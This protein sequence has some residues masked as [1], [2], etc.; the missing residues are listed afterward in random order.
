MEKATY[1]SANG[2]A[3][4]IKLP[5]STTA[6]RWKKGIDLPPASLSLVSDNGFKVT[7]LW[8]VTPDI[9][10]EGA[11]VSGL[12]QVHDDPSRLVVRVR[13]L[14]KEGQRSAEVAGR[15]CI[16]PDSKRPLFYDLTPAPEELHED[17]L[18]TLAAELDLVEQAMLRSR[19]NAVRTREEIIGRSLKGEAYK[20]MPFTDARNLEL[21]LYKTVKVAAKSDL[22]NRFPDYRFLTPLTM[23]SSFE[24]FE[25]RSVSLGDGDRIFR[26]S[27]KDSTPIRVFANK[28]VCALDYEEAS[29]LTLYPGTGVLRLSGLR[30]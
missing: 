5:T 11:W 21:P 10:D 1:V 19:K 9:G 25:T 3:R 13:D 24:A 22:E 4:K 23:N 20:N 2:L 17:A 26:V 8:E 14:P 29:Q 30:R 27:P 15:L 12:E 7:P 18:N 6:H 16:G 28:L